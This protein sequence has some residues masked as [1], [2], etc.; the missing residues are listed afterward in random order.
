MPIVKPHKNI[1][2]NNLFLVPDRDP[3]REA[4]SR[5]M[6]GQ[7]QLETRWW[8][9]WH[10]SAPSPRSAN[11]RVPLLPGS[12]F[13]NGNVCLCACRAFILALYNCGMAAYATSWSSYELREMEH[14]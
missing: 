13:I 1:F 10:V 14:I 9:N 8:I 7:D 2:K 3:D 11:R 12:A 5:L 6:E 4:S